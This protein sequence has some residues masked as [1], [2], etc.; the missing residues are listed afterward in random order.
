[1]AE[2]LVPLGVGRGVV[3]RAGAEL[4]AGDECLVPADGFL[5]VG[6]DP[7]CEVTMLV[8]AFETS[9]PYGLMV[10]VAPESTDPHEDWDASTETVHARPDSLYISVRQA[11][12]GL[13]KV[14]C[15]E[16]EE[17][18]PDLDLLFTG[19]LA[20]PSARLRI[21]DPDETI[22]VILSVDGK[23]MTVTT[24]ANDDDEPSDLEIY[25]SAGK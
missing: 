25:L 3:F 19:M 15:F 24:Y 6:L 13:V 14:K 8:S 1:V 20:L 22:S 23:S 18:R 9:F 2:E 4:A 17:L 10:V 7:N 11:S 5:G 12:S 16:G 21:Y